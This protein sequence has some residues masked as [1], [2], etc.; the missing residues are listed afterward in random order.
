[1]VGKMIQFLRKHYSHQEVAFHQVHYSK[2]IGIEKIYNKI[3]FV[4]TS[5]MKKYIWTRIA[6]MC[7]KRKDLFITRGIIISRKRL[8]HNQMIFEYM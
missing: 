1:M 3:S 6:L 5:S 7:K 4:Y 2:K 8:K